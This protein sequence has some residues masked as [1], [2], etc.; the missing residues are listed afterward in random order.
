PVYGTFTEGT[1]IYNHS[2]PEEMII[3][4]GNESSGIDEM[5]LPWI[6][7]KIAIPEFPPG[8][9]SVESLNIAS[10]VAVIVSEARRTKQV[11]DYSK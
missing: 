3:L 6:T 10:A 7:E 8:K 2:C 1:A 5:L 4:F 9:K 11:D